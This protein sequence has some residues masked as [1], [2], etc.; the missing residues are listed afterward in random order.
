MN[1][2][3]RQNTSQE[4]R[5]ETNK[6]EDS[7]KPE[8]DTALRDHIKARITRKPNRIIKRSFIESAMFPEDSA[9]R[10]NT[11]T[12]GRRSAAVRSAR[13]DAPG[14]TRRL[15]SAPRTTGGGR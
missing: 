11:G 4:T 10:A 5:L 6:P 2:E 14:T 15:S 13:A 3:T 8:R 7:K 1:Q 9:S 12:I